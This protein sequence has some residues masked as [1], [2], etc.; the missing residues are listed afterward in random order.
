[1]R[2]QNSLQL[3]KVKKSST[4]S[5]VSK[6][7]CI[8]ID[9]CLVLDY[10]RLVCLAAVVFSSPPCTGGWTGCHL[11]CTSCIALQHLW[12][13]EKSQFRNNR[14]EVG[15]LFSGER[16]FLGPCCCFGLCIF[17]FYRWRGVV[18]SKTTDTCITYNPLCLRPRADT[19]R[20]NVT[21]HAS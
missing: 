3:T 16:A 10:C 20:F 18:T 7:H 15:S 12:K 6:I 2:I 8:Y 19:R 5:W 21:A 11:D 13:S 17:K 4:I 14:A 1:M 9:S